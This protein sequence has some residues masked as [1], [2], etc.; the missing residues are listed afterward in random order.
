MYRSVHFHLCTCIFRWMVAL[1][2]ATLITRQL[3]FFETQVS[4]SSFALYGFSMDQSTRS[5]SSTWVSR[6]LLYAQ[7]VRY[8]NVQSPLS[9]CSVKPTPPL[10][11]V[12]G[13]LNPYYT[14]GKKKSAHWSF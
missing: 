13:K 14:Q 6:R 8:L 9:K 11:T 10:F 3:K 2:K 4:R 12:E 1:F 5:F 7:S